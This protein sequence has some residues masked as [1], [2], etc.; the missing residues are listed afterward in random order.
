MHSASTLTDVL[1]SLFPLLCEVGI[2]T[3]EKALSSITRKQS[4]PMTRALDEVGGGEQELASNLKKMM[5]LW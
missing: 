5:G 3:L 2:T 4:S 1:Y